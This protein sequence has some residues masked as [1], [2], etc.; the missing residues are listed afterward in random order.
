MSEVGAIAVSAGAIAVGAIIL[1][2]YRGLTSKFS[3]LTY[4]WWHSGPLRRKFNV[5]D[6]P[7][8]AVGAMLAMVGIL[9]LVIAIFWPAGKR[10]G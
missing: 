3:A 1:F 2:D 8:R 6:P 5:K 9:I 10:S 7:F 4:K